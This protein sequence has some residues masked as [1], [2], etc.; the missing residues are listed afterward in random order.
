MNTEL[1]PDALEEIAAAGHE[2]GFHAWRHEEWA[3]LPVDVQAADLARGMAGL[4][5]IGIGVAGMRPPGGG[6]G[7][8][9]SGVVRRRRPPLLLAGR[10][11]RRR[12]GRASPSS[13][14]SGA[15]STPAACCRRWAPVRKQIAGSRSP[16]AGRVHRLPR[17]RARPPRRRRRLPHASS[18]TSSCRSGS[19]ASGSNALLDRLGAAPR[20]RAADR[21]AAGRAG[22]AGARR[23]PTSSPG[24]LA[25]DT[26][27]WS[28]LS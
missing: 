26:A 5:R 10:R 6:L 27:S 9:G 22:G 11:G 14:S 21:R 19:A 13:P 12:R 15:T 24:R 28:L 4:E 7:A 2:V 23:V 16:R 25:L 8:G 1:Y 3:K 17:A 18:S 20:E